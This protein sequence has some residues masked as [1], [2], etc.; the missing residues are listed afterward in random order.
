M[1]DLGTEGT[2]VAVSFGLVAL[3][4]MGDKSQL[5]CMTLAARHRARM[6]F[7]GAVSAFL[8]L[9]LLAVS[10]GAA[11]AAW[12]PE[13][14]LQGAA[15]LLFAYFGI[16]SLRDLSDGDDE[17]VAITERS[18]RGVYVSAFLMIFVAELGDK[19]QLAVATMSVT[20]SPLA[21]WL[22]A[23]LALSAT[24]ALGCYAGRKYLRKL[25]ARKLHFASG[26]FFLLLAAAMVWRLLSE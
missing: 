7:A 26:L 24:T 10:V 13:A 21:V 5:V 16:Q 23:S 12:L 17:C 6:V 22:G 15:A 3:A 18:A 20:E 4:E 9:N 19:T 25:D 8:L 14:W 1:F 2:T 11:I